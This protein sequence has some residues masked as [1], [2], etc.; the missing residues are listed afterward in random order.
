MWPEQLKTLARIILSNLNFKSWF[1]RNYITL[2]H[3]DY[4]IRK[5]KS[6]YQ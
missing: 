4:A 2:L 1:S 3:T 6:S 5:E